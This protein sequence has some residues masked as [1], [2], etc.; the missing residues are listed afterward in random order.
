MDENS[1]EQRKE[2]R[3]ERPQNRHLKPFPPGVS[4]NPGGRPKGVSLTAR[5]REALDELDGD[6]PKAHKL[7]DVLMTVAMKGDRQAIK[8][9]ME[10]VDGKVPDRIAGHD[11]GPLNISLQWEHGNDDPEPDLENA[12]PAPGPGSGAET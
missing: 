2:Q 4:G 6:K 3:G 1:Q 5:L 7:I 9:I 8:D 10:R 11:G 12:P